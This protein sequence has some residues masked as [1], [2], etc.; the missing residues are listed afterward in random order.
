MEKMISLFL[1]LFASCFA[2]DYYIDGTNGNDSTGDGTIGTPW[3][4]IQKGVTAAQA[5]ETVYIRT[6]TYRETINLVRSGSLGSPITIKAY[7]GESVCLSGGKVLDGVGSDITQ[8]VWVQCAADEAFL[9]RN[10]TNHAHATSIYKHRILYTDI[11]YTSSTLQGARLALFNDKVFATYAMN[12]STGSAIAPEPTDQSFYIPNSSGGSNTSSSSTLID[13]SGGPFG[14]LT[15]DDYFHDCQ[16]WIYKYGTGAT[17]Y[18]RAVISADVSA[19]SLTFQT[20]GIVPNAST[21]YAIGNNPVDVDSAGEYC[22]ELTPTEGYINVYYYANNETELTD[23]SMSFGYLGEAISWTNQSTVY[24]FITLEDLEICNYAR[25]DSIGTTGCMLH[26]P[27]SST[28]KRIGWTIKHCNVHD[29]AW[30]YFQYGPCQDL[31]VE[32]CTLNNIGYESGGGTWFSFKQDG[33][34]SDTQNVYIHNNTITGYCRSTGI[35]LKRC[36]NVLIYDNVINTHHSAHGN[37]CSFYEGTRNVLFAY[38]QSIGDGIR[39]TAQ[40]IGLAGA[41]TGEGGDIWIYSNIFQTSSTDTVTWETNGWT[42]RNETGRIFFVNNLVTQDNATTYIAYR[43]RS[44][45]YLL[46]YCYNNILEVTDKYAAQPPGVRIGSTTFSLGTVTEVYEK[47]IHLSM[48]SDQTTTI[49]NGDGTTVSAEIADYGAGHRWENDLL[50]DGL[51]ERTAPDDILTDFGDHTYADGDFDPLDHEDIVNNG[52]DISSIVPVALYGSYVNFNRDLRGNPRNLTAPTIGPLEYVAGGGSAPTKAN[53]PSPANSAT[54]VGIVPAFT[55]VDGGDADSYD[56][57]AGIASPLTSQNLL[58]SSLLSESYNPSSQM[59]YNTT[60][61][62]RVDSKN[63][64]GT[65]TGDTWSFTTVASPPLGFVIPNFVGY[66]QAEAE[67]LIDLMGLVL[68]TS[69]WEYNNSV[70]YGIVISQEPDAYSEGQTG[71]TVNLTYSQGP[72]PTGN[73][74]DAMNVTATVT[75]SASLRQVTISGSQLAGSYEGCVIMI[76]SAS[77]GKRAIAQIIGYNST[78]NTAYLNRDIGFTPQPGDSVLIGIYI[79]S[80]IYSGR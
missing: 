49:T 30:Y 38:N 48:D 50:C 21:P 6:G 78:T 64:Y 11:P 74:S 68:G 69:L 80:T 23:G 17:V 77:T 18:F 75:T 66:T 22:F 19:S 28:A 5:G 4:T 71:E 41:A 45:S 37:G 25:P 7:N 63:A 54:D 36:D 42:N 15:D 58:A 32:N 29:V 60:F 57:Y 13:S 2:T 79:P 12:P 14:G 61:Y 9:K 34:N 72:E 39:M 67:S 33:S 43:Q 16:V 10:G 8:D 65:T 47:N 73:E 46:A 31:T 55:W 44:S 40:C 51:S 70:G 3:A 56:F 52:K 20:L 53:T 35:Q 76:K 59:S 26:T 1:I 27:T 62:W 24:N